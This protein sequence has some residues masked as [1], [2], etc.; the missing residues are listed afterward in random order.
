MG[1]LGRLAWRDVLRAWAQRRPG[2]Q[3]VHCRG[4]K[5]TSAEVPAQERRESGLFGWSTGPS[6]VAIGPGKLHEEDENIE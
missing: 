6:G 5:R 2:R 3:F 1:Q 4:R